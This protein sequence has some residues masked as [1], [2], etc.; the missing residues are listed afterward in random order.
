[1]TRDISIPSL[2]PDALTT[3]RP[4]ILASDALARGRRQSLAEPEL[5][6]AVFEAVT[7][8][9]DSAREVLSRAADYLAAQ[10]AFMGKHAPGQLAQVQGIAEGYGIKARDLFAYLHLGLI[11]DAD[12][13]TLAEEDGC[14]V[15]ACRVT[16][17]GPVLAKNRDYRGEHRA[18]QRV[19]LESD[20]AWGGRRILSVGSLG[21]PGAFSSGM[22]SD[23]LALADTRIGWRRPGVGWLRYLLMNEILIRAG[24]VLEALSFI[25]SQPHAGGGSLVLMDAAGHAATVE[26]GTGRVRSQS[27]VQA[28]IGH[29]N[30]FL[31]PDLMTGQTPSPGDPEASNSRGRLARIENWIEDT[32]TERPALEDLATLMASHVEDD[33][34]A[35]CRHGGAD[36]SGTISTTVFACTSRK[37]Y[38]CPGNPCTD[39]WRLYAF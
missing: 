25:E 33:R 38:S 9:L 12:G 34:P 30:H 11:E 7:G 28:G 13:Q 17:T 23:G 19:F 27:A 22:N 37:L 2:A 15:V 4:V 6:S 1:M 16:S 31:D 32:K 35:L 36:G 18:L 24:T 39:D 10:W 26:L 29:T 8:R 14:S 3:G 5:R 20:P 21:S